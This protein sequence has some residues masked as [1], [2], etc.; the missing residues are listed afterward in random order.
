MKG[1]VIFC[2][3]FVIP[4]VGLFIS[5]AF[6]LPNIGFMGAGKRQTTRSSG[7]QADKDINEFP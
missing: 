1:L 7:G 2:L 3:I 4:L 6:L 5:I